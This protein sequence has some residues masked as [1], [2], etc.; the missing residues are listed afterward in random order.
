MTWYVLLAALALCIFGILLLLWSRQQRRATGLPAGEVVYSDT[1]AETKVLE[2]LVS[3][4][5]GLVGK[6]DYLVAVTGGSDRFMAPMEVKSGRQ[7]HPPH[8]GHVLQLATYCLI[9]EDVYGKRPLFGYLRY[10]D[11]TLKI[12]FSDA[13]RAEV[14]QTAQAIRAARTAATV[15]RSHHIAPRCARCGYLDGCGTEAL[16]GANN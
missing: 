11:A 10:A 5:F 13:L 15:H 4:R 12:A 6:P 7:P 16:R 9:V 3:R 14:L 2:S 1:G 8:A